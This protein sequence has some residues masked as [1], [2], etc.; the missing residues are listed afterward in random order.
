MARL[1]SILMILMFKKFQIA[2]G[3]LQQDRVTVLTEEIFTL[4]NPM[5]LQVLQ[6]LPQL[7]LLHLQVSEEQRF[8]LVQLTQIL[9]TLLR[10]WTVKLICIKQLITL[11][12]LLH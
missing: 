4:Q 6:E 11:Q 8:L 7:G 5:E 10:V 3:F 9:I 12:Q 2:F 1:E